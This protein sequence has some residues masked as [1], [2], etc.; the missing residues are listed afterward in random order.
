MS[1]T[2]T[3]T[4]TTKAAAAVGLAVETTGPPEPSLMHRS[5]RSRPVSV[6]SG[7]GIYLNLWN[8]RRVLDGCA[9]A[10]VAILGHGHPAVQAA[11]VEQ[12]AKVSYVHTAK[13]TTDSAEDLADLIL[14]TRPF[15]L[16]KAYFVGS[17][18]EAMDSAM[19]LA[20]QFHYERGETHRTKWVARRQ[21]YHGNTV[22]AMSVS[23]NRARRVPY[24]DSLLLGGVSF[25][26]PANSYRG[27][28][29]TE[30][31]E[32]F[33]ERLIKE[34]DEE[35]RRIGPRSVIAFIAETV[36]GATGGCV[37]APKGYFER[38]RKLC[39]EYGILLILDEVMCGSGRTGSYFAFEHEGDVVPDI[40][41]VGKGLGGGYAPIAGIYIHDKVV[42]ALR[43]GSAAYNHGHTYQ[44]HPVS[45]AAA[46]ATQ[47]VVKSL[48]LV[49]ACAEKGMILGALLRDRLG[50]K[51][52]VGDVRGRGLFWAVEFVEDKATKKPLDLSVGFSGRLQQ[53]C[54]DLGLDIYPG[55]GT[56]DGIV[57]DH[58][59]LTPPLTI[60]PDQ[61]Q[62]MVDILSNAYDT[63]EDQ[64]GATS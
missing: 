61:L 31:E 53:E 19:K 26:D 46:L 36:G 15:G 62:S 2:T 3:S 18:S 4:I 58:I 40:V 59:L 11:I 50:E 64:L 27:Q 9:G 20:R 7:S 38:V 57:G 22:G 8:G 43:Q 56:V 37:T 35:F 16:S 34:L 54:F 30:T 51:K 17:G 48:G 49:E 23:S 13:Y 1:S 41:T 25:V 47:Q 44:A 52:Y 39:D 60:T 21:A 10:A 14:G 45:C 42:H 6:Q 29:A 24:E 55:Q 5:L 28:L 33:V 12:V 63:L 32:Q